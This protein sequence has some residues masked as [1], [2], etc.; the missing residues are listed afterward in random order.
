M[1]ET[2]SDPRH[3]R[4]QCAPPL[5]PDPC[6][7]VGGAVGPHWRFGLVWPDVLRGT[8]LAAASAT[9]STSATAPPAAQC[10]ANVLTLLVGQVGILES[11]VEVRR[12]VSIVGAFVPA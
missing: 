4:L 7:C 8:R 5:D 6:P 3:G 12:T 1:A 11:F 10:S 2:M 9:T